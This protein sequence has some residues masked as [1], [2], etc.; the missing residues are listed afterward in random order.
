[1]A[2]HGRVAAPALAGGPVGETP[3]LNAAGP[4]YVALAADVT[5]A[6]GIR[7]LWRQANGAGH[8]TQGLNDHLAKR[9]AEIEA[10]TP[11]ADDSTCADCS[12]PIDDCQCAPAVQPDADGVVE[13]ELVPDG[14]ADA[15]WQ[16]ILVAGHTQHGWGLS[17]VTADFKSSMG[18][19]PD[20]A[21]APELSAYLHQLVTG[22]QVPA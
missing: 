15:I 14:D 2:G 11:P 3:A 16:Q 4:D 13:G 10:A 6:E 20:E 18:M 22:E 1:M 19:I 17:D 21:A 8:M 12:H 5:D 9:V 7:D